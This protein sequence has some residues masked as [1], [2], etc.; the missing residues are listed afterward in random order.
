MILKQT[1]LKIFNY[2]LVRKTELIFISVEDILHKY[3]DV[4]F[5][6]K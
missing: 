4:F 3:I 6:L 2:F 1:K 5:G